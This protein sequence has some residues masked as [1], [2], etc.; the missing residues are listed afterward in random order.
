MMEQVTQNNWEQVTCEMRE[1]KVSCELIRNESSKVQT[2][3]SEVLG[4]TKFK[5]REMECQ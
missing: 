2:S 4:R 1:S 5:E 3:I